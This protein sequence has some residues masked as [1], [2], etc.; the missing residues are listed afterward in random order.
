VVQG[1]ENTTRAHDTSLPSA[2]HTRKL[3]LPPV[4]V[5]EIRAH[6]LPISED[7][8]ILCQFLSEL[9][10]A[11]AYGLILTS[12]DGVRFSTAVETGRLSGSGAGGS[13][14]EIKNFGAAD[15]P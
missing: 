14:P 3:L 10:Q 6:A 13:V 2:L 8:L 9:L 4:S 7:T 12:L 5:G 11:M 1:V 15:Y